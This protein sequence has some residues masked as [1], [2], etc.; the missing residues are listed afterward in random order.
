MRAGRFPHQP[1]SH[2]RD[3]RNRIPRPVVYEDESLALRL[4][5]LPLG[6]HCRPTARASGFSSLTV[7]NNQ[8]GANS[9][10]A[11]RHHKASLSEAVLK[12]CLGLR[13]NPDRADSPFSRTVKTRTSAARSSRGKARKAPRM[14]WQTIPG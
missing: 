12:T 8:G 2:R 9:D 6:N 1:T 10:F 5:R 7:V 13:R 4:C 11:F 14:L 3:G